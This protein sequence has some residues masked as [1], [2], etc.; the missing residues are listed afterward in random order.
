MNLAGL[1]LTVV[2]LIILVSFGAK[3]LPTCSWNLQGK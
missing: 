1:D 2:L 3:K